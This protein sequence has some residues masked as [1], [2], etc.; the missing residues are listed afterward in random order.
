MLT[1]IFMVPK[2]RKA[3]LCVSKT[4]FMS[5]F[6]RGVAVQDLS[7]TA[8]AESARILPV[9]LNALQVLCTSLKSHFACPRTEPILA[10]SGA[11]IF[12]SVLAAR[13]VGITALFINLKG[14]SA[15]LSTAP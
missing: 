10:G 11:T 15:V 14:C 1:G 7:F 13:R 5:R 3:K 12:D 8:V 4:A 9:G 2:L 6:Q